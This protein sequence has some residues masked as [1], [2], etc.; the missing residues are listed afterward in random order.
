M[1][2]QHPYDA[3]I[4]GGSYAGLSAAL[5][6][7][8]SLRKVLIIDGG[9][10]CNRFS[11]HAHNFL[12]HDGRSP[13][14]I[15]QLARQELNQYA[16]VRFR[17]D[18]VTQVNAIQDG[19]SVRTQAGV[20]FSAHKLL[21]ATGVRDR[22]PPLPGFA[23]CW[24]RSILHCPY[25][26]GYEVRGKAIGVIG[27]G[28]MG[29]DFAR[30]LSNW[31]ENLTLFTDG[32][33]TLNAEETAALARHGITIVEGALRSFAH[34]QGQL[35]HVVLADGRQ[36]AVD[37]VFARVPFEQQSPIATALGCAMTPEGF[38]EVDDYQRTSVP[39]VYA[40]GDCASMFRAVAMAVAA[41]NKAGAVL[42][43]ELI[44]ER[45]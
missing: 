45:F 43:R 23:D 18:T 37:A 39:G 2:P 34:D 16:T 21:L 44:D 20:S 8:R 1:Q 5:A 27:N 15:R 3:I 19:F 9:Q 29:F 6:L 13:D 22:M 10:P 17:E 36:E 31:S 24:G 40:A 7:G 14:A 32:T 35:H 11:P 41:G 12:T 33:S 28:E 38:V 26:H 4:I 30:L 25:C 42:N